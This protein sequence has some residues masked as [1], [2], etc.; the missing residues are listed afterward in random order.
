MVEYEYDE[1]G[2]VRDWTLFL[3]DRYESDFDTCELLAVSGRDAYPLNFQLS[4]REAG[5]GNS[6]EWW[7][8]E[9]VSEW[10]L[11]RSDF[12]IPSPGAPVM[13]SFV[14]QL[15]V[16]CVRYDGPSVFEQVLIQDYNGPAV[17]RWV[18]YTPRYSGPF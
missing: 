12:R 14:D 16:N 3:Q 1:R 15:V 7:E 18:R 8:W 9:W 11:Q 4:L 13:P 6:R 5:T 17:E 10:E 2:R